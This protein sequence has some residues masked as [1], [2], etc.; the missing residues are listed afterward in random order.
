MNHIMPQFIFMG[1]GIMVAFAV[2]L[3]MYGLFNIFK[4]FLPERIGD[5]F[6]DLAKIF[7]MLMVLSF[8]LG[9]LYNSTSHIST[10]FL[11]TDPWTFGGFASGS[12]SF[13]AGLFNLGYSNLGAILFIILVLYGMGK[14]TKKF[15]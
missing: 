8:L 1:G 5:W 12:I 6:G 9:I 11:P 14:I 13:F 7:Y 15:E 3:M 2:C 10:G 4:M